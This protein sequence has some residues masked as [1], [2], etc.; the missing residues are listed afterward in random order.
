MA[1]SLWLIALKWANFIAGTVANT[2]LNS[3][4]NSDK[5]EEENRLKLS[6]F[7]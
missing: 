5:E 4:H 1:R 7:F 6:I 2:N 3:K